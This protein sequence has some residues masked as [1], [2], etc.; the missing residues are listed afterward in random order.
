MRGFP[1][2]DCHHLGDASFV[3]HELD[4]DVS[5]LNKIA[6]FFTSRDSS[7]FFALCKLLVRLFRMECVQ[8]KPINKYFKLKENET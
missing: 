1:P 2:D 3:Y 5:L 8:H 7:F 4:F 6:P